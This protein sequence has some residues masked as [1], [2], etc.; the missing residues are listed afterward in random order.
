MAVNFSVPSSPARSVVQINQFLGVDYTNSPANVDI[1]KSPN[2]QNMIRDV[3][4]KVRKCMG[5]HTIQNYDARI[6]GCHYR[7]GDSSFI[8]HAGTKIYKGTTV[9]YS[10]ANN[11]RSRSWQY[12]NKLYIADG[13]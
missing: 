4:G 5:Y 3:P 7:R 9:L 8:V 12:G 10:G 13:N 1:E 11:E 2:G 6:N